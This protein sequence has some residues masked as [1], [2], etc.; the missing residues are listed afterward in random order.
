MNRELERGNKVRL[1]DI[2]QQVI[3]EVF[4]KHFG[5]EDHLW[6]F[7]SRVDDTK[8]GGDIDLFIESLETDPQV[9]FEKKLDFLVEVKT[10]IGDQ[11]IDI[12]IGSPQDDALIY[13]QAR[14]TGIRLV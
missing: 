13:E 1:T 7:G 10:K 11:K 8:R 4:K 3:V 6:L 2:Q 9:T 12:V 14:L 5:P